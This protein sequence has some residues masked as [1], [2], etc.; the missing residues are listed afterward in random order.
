MNALDAAFCSL[1][2]ATA[3]LIQHGWNGEGAIEAPVVYALAKRP[4]VFKYVFADR[5][6][7]YK[8]EYREAITQGLQEAGFLVTWKFDSEHRGVRWSLISSLRNMHETT[9]EVHS[10]INPGDSGPGA[11]R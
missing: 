11:P 10:G 7:V 5:K 3:Y 8:D 2:D 9:F 4:E 6:W 1:K